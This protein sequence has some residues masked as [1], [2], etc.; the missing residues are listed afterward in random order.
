[1]NTASKPSGLK[2]KTARHQAGL[3]QAALARAAGVSERNIV[4]WENDQ[5]T[6][7][8]E[9]IAA[10]AAATGKDVSFFLADGDG[11]DEEEPDLPLDLDA[12]LRSYLR[13]LIQQEARA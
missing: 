11:S 13:K 5:H 8:F 6:P 12:A 10:I 1:M 7:R 3:T 4:R 9:H 2:I